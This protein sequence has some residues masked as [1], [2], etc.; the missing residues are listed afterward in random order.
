MFGS[1]LTVCVSSSIL[2]ARPISELFGHFACHLFWSSIMGCLW[3][4][5]TSGLSMALVRFLIVRMPNFAMIRI[6]V[7]NLT[8]SAVAIQLATVA[9]VMMFHHS[10]I[11]A[12]GTSTSYQYCYGYST[13]MAEMVWLHNQG[14]SYQARDQAEDKRKFIL[15]FAL[16]CFCLTLVLYAS[17]LWHLHRHDRDIEKRG[18]I[19]RDKVLMRRKKNAIT[20]V[21]Q[22]AVFAIEIIII[23]VCVFVARS[24]TIL[25][26]QRT[27]IP[28]LTIEFAMALTVVSFL[29]SHEYRRH[30][31]LG[32]PS[33][34]VKV[35]K[36][37]KAKIPEEIE[38][39]KASKTVP[40][41]LSAN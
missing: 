18:V 6:G 17:I 24:G 13:E 26:V 23:Y 36:S 12:K 20:A 1:V 39:N 22:A 3:L 32:I 29:G 28:T 21:D 37:R 9:G 15:I 30:Y 33:V 35:L 11:S 16:G 4:L 5:A 41:N 19:G 31:N 10:L 34:L 38:L 8:R 2:M 40:T 27:T 14:G 25:G 7:Q